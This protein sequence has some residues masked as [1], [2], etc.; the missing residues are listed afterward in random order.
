MNSSRNQDLIMAIYSDIRSV[1][2]LNDIAMLVCE[3]NFNSLSWRLNYYVRKGKL[4][5]PRK[6]IYVKEGYN[7]QELA[8]SLYIP[9]YISLEYVLQKAGVVFQYDQRLTI[10]SYLS[11]TIEIENNIYC[12]RKIKGETLIA[13]QGIDRRGNINIA[14]PE[15]AFLDLLYL[16]KKQYLDN[17]GTLN[18]KI[19]YKLLPI[20]N[21]KLLLERAKKILQND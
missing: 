5:S 21:S 4:F 7:P 18:K 8:C 15:R 10:V 1:F 9:S 17:L 2:T 13:T 12:Y 16:N 20:Y 11:R 14:T 3:S 6:G 19:I